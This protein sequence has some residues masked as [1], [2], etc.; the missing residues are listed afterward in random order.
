MRTGFTLQSDYAPR[1]DQGQAIARLAAGIRAGEPHQILL[2]VTGSGKTFTVA[3]V[4]EEIQQPTLVISHNKTLAA[5][6]FNEFKVFFPCNAVEYFVSYYDYYQPEAYLP[7]TDTY[8]EKDSSINQD[9]D[10]LRHSATRSVLERKDVIVVASVSC[11]YG[12]GSPDYYREMKIRLVAGQAVGRQKLLRDLVA[13]RYR[14]ND[15][16]LGRGCFRVRG[17]VVEVY[18]AYEGERMLRVEF[19]GETIEK[20]SWC[21]PLTGR[22]LME[23]EEVA[24]FPGSH[25]VIPDDVLGRAL[26]GIEEELEGR[27]RELKRADK[28]LEAQRL[29]QRTKLD[30]EMMREAGFCSG[31]E[32]YSRHLTGRAPG[33]PPPTLLEYFGEE[34]MVVID[35]SHVSIP[36]L[37][38][39]AAGDRSRKDNLVRHGFRLPSAY[40]NRPMTFGEFER[41]VKQVLYVSATPGPYEMSRA[42]GHVVEQIIRPT[43]LMEPEVEIRP[44]SNQVEDLMEEIRLRAEAGERVLVT[45]LTKRMAEDLTEYYSELGIRVRYLHSEIHTLERMQ[46]LRDLRLGAYDALVGINLLREG[47]DLPEVSLVAVLDADKEGF[48]RS[49]TALVQTAGRA[50]RNV[51]GKVILYADVETGSIRRAVAETRRRREIQRSFNRKEGITPEGIKKEIADVLSSVYENDY[52]TIPATG[53]PGA[54]YVSESELEWRRSSGTGPGS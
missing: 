26:A 10:K 12:L 11:I 47:L 51:S 24:V 28:P 32:N 40:D 17:D 16:D 14:R 38:A 21:D 48:L 35:E 8:I 44:V 5:Q 23:S 3:N 22:A 4:I 31:I 2:G 18:P 34:F 29:E 46:L 9:I 33:T 7:Q 6:L 27:L 50:A 45:T 1:G 52:P 37:R 30:M 53:E 25:Y 39:M 43:G 15:V 20:L 19:F 54:A 36:Q 41:S 42:G 49:E 13:I